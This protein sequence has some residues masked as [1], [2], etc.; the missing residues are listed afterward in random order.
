MSCQ[1]AGRALQRSCL[2]MAAG[3]LL[4][5]QQP[6]A[7]HV[8]S[9]FHWS[10]WFLRVMRGTRDVSSHLRDAAVVVRKQEWGSQHEQMQTG[11]GPLAVGGVPVK[12]PDIGRFTHAE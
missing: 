1:S 4:H 8:T 12:R 10:V 9:S 5:W 6:A 7:G 11:Y 2:S 3:I